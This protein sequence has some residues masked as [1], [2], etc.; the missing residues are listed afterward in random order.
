M[1]KKK[2]NRMRTDWIEIEQ[3]GE[4]ERRESLE[5]RKKIAD[6]K[7]KPQRWSENK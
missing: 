2:N 1:Q 6:L 7:R 4:A 3:K 5:K